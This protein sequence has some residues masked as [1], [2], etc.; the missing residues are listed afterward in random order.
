MLTK[1]ATTRA[2]TATRTGCVRRGLGQYTS[3]SEGGSRNAAERLTAS[4]I[5][6]IEQLAKVFKAFIIV[7]Q[8]THCTAADKLVIPNISLTGSVLSRSH[9]FGTFVRERLEWSQAGV[10]LGRSGPELRPKVFHKGGAR[11]P[12]VV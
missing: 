2:T 3:L 7:V 10:K 12:A 9:G 6:V 5:S 11:A 4:K 1:S 8:E